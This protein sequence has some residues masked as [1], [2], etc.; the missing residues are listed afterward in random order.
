MIP[1]KLQL[2]NFMSY[3]G[4][5][6]L[7]DFTGIHLACLTG[8]NGMGKSTLLD[9]MTWALWG[10]ARARRDD[11]L[12]SHGESDMEVQLEFELNHDLYRVIRKRSS[13]G[14]GSSGLELQG[15]TGNGFF[16]SLSEPTIR[17]SQ[18]RIINLLKLEYDTFVNSAFL[19]QGR[20]DEFTTKKPAERKQ[21]LA[22]I[23]SLAEYDKYAERAKARMRA[24]EEQRKQAEADLE[25]IRQ[26]VE[27]IPL[28]EAELVEAEA[29]VRRLEREVR[30]ATELLNTLQDQRS[31]LDAKADALTQAE[32]RIRK[33]RD[34]VS[35]A[36]ARV[37]E[38]R[39]KLELFDALLIRAEEIEAAMARLGRA[40]SE[41]ERW[42]DLLQRNNE[43]TI[44]AHAIQSAIAEARAQVTGDLRAAE[45]TIRGCR[46]DLDRYAPRERELAEAQKQVEQLLRVQEERGVQQDRLA[47]EMEESG[48]LQAENKM[49]KQQMETIRD[50]MALLD[51]VEAAECPICRQPLSAEARVQAMEAGRKD[52]KER[53]DQWRDNKAQ[54]QQA[55]ERV[56][57]LNAAI[58]SADSQL[59]ELGRWQRQ[60]AQA[61][62]AAEQVLRARQELSAAEQQAQLLRARLEAEDYAREEQARLA[63]LANATASLGYDK[64]AHD[65]A[66]RTIQELMVR[67]QE[68]QA[69]AEA[70]AQR[71]GTVEMV[72][73][74]EE[75][76]Q[77]HQRQVTDVAQE[78]QALTLEL[79]QRA[80]VQRRVQEQQ[81]QVNQLQNAKTTADRSLGGFKQR[82][83]FAE[84]H[85]ARRPE[86]EA[87]CHAAIEERTIYD[88]LAQ[89]FGKRGI[90]AMIIES[91]LPDIEDEANRLLGRM[92]DGRMTVKLQTQREARTG[93][94][95]IETLDILISD[96]YGERPYEM[97][98]G[99]EAFRVNFALRIALSKL[100]AHRAGTSL[101]TL[102]MDEGFGSQDAQGRDRL[103]EAVMS[104]Q[105]DFDRILVITHIEE[106]K[107]AFPIRIE[108]SKDAGGSK[109]TVRG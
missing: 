13:S 25:R 27:Q 17:E 11:D 20:A 62:Q 51:S 29:E 63:D 37:D 108:V 45:E 18:Q 8:D 44:E 76:V 60:H 3:R 49:L 6:N 40:R 7:V 10:K 54:V 69:L 88:Q 93:E 65:A 15:R 2:R 86:V 83:Q 107:E 102:V 67:E 31:L 95:L 94:G 104:V 92:T 55:A 21:I 9:A 82:L 61:S 5:D 26:E 12:I 100:L 72:Q 81:V 77:N 42:D 50:Q 36:Q 98:S 68:A 34:E 97:F 106:L 101:R 79:Q 85:A 71:S 23:L 28:I 35:K 75:L 73:T 22:D 46:A 96:E 47:H 43:L 1:V 70:R 103:V 91:A 30:T 80:E 109:V 4:N 87:A 14:R 39:R 57:S 59:R 84:Q 78:I 66:R 19:L 24:A 74:L 16:A 38:Q 56:K 53:G 105:D 58:S 64:A 33:A 90:Q 99:G 52:G 32:Q 89:A 41:K 48:R